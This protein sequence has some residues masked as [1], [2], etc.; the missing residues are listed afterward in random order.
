MGVYHGYIE[1][2]T[3]CAVEPCS[4]LVHKLCPDSPFP[5]MCYVSLNTYTVTV[6]PLSDCLPLR[7]S[8]PKLFT[9]CVYGAAAADIRGA[10]P[11][12]ATCLSLR[13]TNE[14]EQTPPSVPM[15][16]GI[17]ENAPSSSWDP[18]LACI[19]GS[20]YWLSMGIDQSGA[21]PEVSHFCDGFK[22][23]ASLT[24]SMQE[25]LYNHCIEAIWFRRKMA[26]WSDVVVSPFHSAD[27]SYATRW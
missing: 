11:V 4:P 21:F 12:T 25:K 19:Y 3:P 24:S 5:L 13:D 6:S 23:A 14:T 17:A 10:Y 15:W 2:F 22:E 18:V 1:H 7:S 27:T 20:M 8:N 16:S 9:A 26:T